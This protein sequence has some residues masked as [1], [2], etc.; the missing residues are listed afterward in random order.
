[1]GLYDYVKY[2][3]NCPNCGEK[4]DQFQTNDST[5]EMKE[6]NFW[7]IDKFYDSCENCNTWIEFNRI[8]KKPFVPIE[9]YEMKW[10]KN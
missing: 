1:M 5:C 7:E 9:H 4:V 6:V 2:S 3:M 10:S 8:E